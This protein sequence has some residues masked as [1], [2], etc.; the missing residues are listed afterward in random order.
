MKNWM[1]FGVIGLVILAG[2]AIVAASG[3]DGE[4]SGQ[5]FGSVSVVGSS[6][7]PYAA[8]ADAAVGMAAPTVQG[9]DYTLAPGEGPAVVAFLA[10]WC[11]HCQAEVPVIQDLVDNGEI[12]ENVNLVG[13]A[14]SI[15]RTAGN[16]PPG[17]WLEREGWTSPL[18]FDDQASTAGEAYGVTSFPMWVVLD[19]DGNVVGRLA[20]RI[21][22][23]G[24]KQLLD[25]AAES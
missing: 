25:V 11:S 5:A 17:A 19:S 14:T 13:V 24:I 22:E 21:G 10:H 6:L 2:A 1:W 9:E 3:A 7:P 4:E 23:D 16:Y 18:I 20:G 8:G 15:D 12:P